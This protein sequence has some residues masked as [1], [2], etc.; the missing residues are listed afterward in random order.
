MSFEKSLDRVL[1]RYKE[2][3]NI[4][5]SGISSSS[6]NFVNLSR[7]LSELKSVVEEIEKLQAAKI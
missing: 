1:A 3:L 4:L 6:K 2:L 7:E 5:G